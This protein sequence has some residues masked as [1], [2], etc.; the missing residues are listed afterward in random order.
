MAVGQAV[1]FDGRLVACNALDREP[2]AIDFRRYAL[3]DDSTSTF[4]G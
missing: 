4:S 2:A 1:G 3:D